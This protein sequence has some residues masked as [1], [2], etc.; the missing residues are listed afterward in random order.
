[1]TREFLKGLGLEDAAIDKILDENMRDIGKEKGNTVKA[2]N[3][4]AAEQEKLKTALADLEKLQKSN[5]DISALQKQ[6]SELQAKYEKE[7]GDLNAQL[8]ERDYADAITRSIAGKGLKFSS[9]SA[10]KA[11]ISTLKEQKLEL[12]DGELTGL[13]DFIKSQRE[14]D[15]DAFAPDKEPPRFITGGDGGGHGAPGGGKT[16]AELMAE[17]I[18]KAGAERGKAANNIIST[19][20]GGTT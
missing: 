16:T 9:K 11:F 4:L 10:E 18:G 5:G 12:K 2:Q 17:A 15:P 19:Y 8:A 14:S 6:L 13:D 3:D 7:T 1:M 20:K